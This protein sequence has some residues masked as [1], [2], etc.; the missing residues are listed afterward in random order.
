MP[1][2]GAQHAPE[3]DPENNNHSNNKGAAESK[4][5]IDEAM[6]YLTTR[7]VSDN[8]YSRKQARA[9]LDAGLSPGEIDDFFAYLLS[10]A[11]GKDNRS[12]YALS[13][14]ADSARIEQWRATQ[15]PAREEQRRERV[16]C[17]VCGRKADPNKVHPHGIGDPCFV[18][19]E[20]LTDPESNQEEI[21]R[22]VW[23]Y[24]NPEEAKKEREKQM[25]TFR[26]QRK[27]GEA[28]SA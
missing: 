15:Q 12:G 19:Q 24:M 10:F 2:G 14:M 26:Q 7:G 13:L 21:E 27:H 6:E 16:D 8:S 20:V 25:A 1:Q 18:T 4:E 11:N 22:L 9:A 28:R 17:P 3:Q 23:E 5:S